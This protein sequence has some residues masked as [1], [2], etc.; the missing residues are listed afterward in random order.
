MSEDIVRGLQKL[1]IRGS[2]N[3]WSLNCKQFEHIKPATHSSQSLPFFEEVEEVGTLTHWLD[4]DETVLSSQQ[5]L[6]NLADD[7]CHFMQDGSRLSIS[8]Y[9]G[10]DMLKNYDNFVPLTTDQLENMTGVRKFID[11]WKGKNGQQKLTIV[12]SRHNLIDLIMAPFSD[13]AVHLN[14]IHTG[15][16]LHIFPDRQSVEQCTGI[17][18]KDARIKKICYSGFEL[19]NLITVP[20]TPNRRSA[21]YSIVRGKIDSNIECLFKAEMD[22]IDPIANTYTEIKCSSG[23]KPRNT[24]HR[25]KLL[26]MWVQT[27]LIPSTDLLIGIRD[28]YYNQL[29]SFERYTRDQLYRKFNNSNLNFIRRNYNYN[30]NVSVQWFDHIMKS[31]CKLITPH[32]PSDNSELTSF[33]ITL[34][35]DLCLKLRKLDN[36]PTNTMF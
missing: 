11:Q 16:Y 22:C 18:S 24:Y 27:S 23:L 35:K 17:H 36:T 14:A 30:A 20:P 29:A 32:L 31:I 3:E 19:E 10:H 1:S 6:A 2:K 13:Q 34:T 9:I 25:L 26:R 12:C 7:L 4:T 5:G 21:F 28:P 15:G 8:K 33:K